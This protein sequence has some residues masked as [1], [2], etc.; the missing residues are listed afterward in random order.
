MKIRFKIDCLKKMVGAQ[1]DI[2]LMNILQDR[3]K[4]SD[5]AV[6]LADVAEE[7]LDEAIDTLE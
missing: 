3:G 2:E 5:N 7:D 6:D 1:S 4:V